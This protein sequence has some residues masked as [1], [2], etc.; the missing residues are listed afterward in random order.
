VAFV[1]ESSNGTDNFTVTDSAGQTWTQTASGYKSESGTGPR[2][3][4]FYT[5]NS[6]AVTS[7]TANFTTSGGVIKPGVM[8]MEISGAASSSVVDGSVN[9]IGGASCRE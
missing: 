1:R 3:G 5:A 8:V 6:T 2:I 7:V 9:Q 4:M